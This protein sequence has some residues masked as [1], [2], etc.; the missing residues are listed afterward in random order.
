MGDMDPL[1]SYAKCITVSFLQQLFFSLPSLESS[2]AHSIIVL[3]EN[4]CIYLA[5]HLS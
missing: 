2:Q 1:Y 3:T 5:T 4:T